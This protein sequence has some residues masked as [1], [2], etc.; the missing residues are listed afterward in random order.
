MSVAVPATT[1][2][3]TNQ[4]QSGSVRGA[5]APSKPSPLSQPYTAPDASKR[6]S[7]DDSDLRDGIPDP[8][9]PMLKSGGLKGR[10]R[11]ALSF[12]A[13]NSLDEESSEP[14]LGSRRQVVAAKNMAEQQKDK[15]KEKQ[16]QKQK[17][18]LVTPT[19]N[20][21]APDVNTSPVS[22]DDLEYPDPSIRST[23]VNG[24]RLVLQLYVAEADGNVTIIHIIIQTP[25]YIIFTIHCESM[26]A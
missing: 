16:K 26:M 17:D 1:N 10:L 6:L 9:G 14:K 18:P 4:N 2:S 5:R 24:P 13:I 19:K 21:P 25:V 15:E 11:R 7:K 12:S 20:G 22:T 3:A 23:K 8:T